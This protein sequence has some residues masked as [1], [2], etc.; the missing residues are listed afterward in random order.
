MQCRDAT[1]VQPITVQTSSLA[2]SIR[3]LRFVNPLL[4]TTCAESSSKKSILLLSTKYYI[5]AVT[6]KLTDCH[7]NTRSI[8]LESCFSQSIRSLMS[9]FYIVSAIWSSTTQEI[10]TNI[11][12]FW[13]AMSKRNYN[14]TSN[15]MRSYFTLQFLRVKEMTYFLTAMF[16]NKPF[17][18]EDHILIKH[19]YRLKGFT[20]RS[21]WKNFKLRIERA[22]YPEA[23]KKI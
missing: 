18:K 19:L 10:W 14:F 8:Q 3:H 7:S 1:S 12:N 21:C 22:K 2:P 9:I 16:I 17:S 15:L 11:H 13:R 4:I 5:P 23:V 20:T 6:R